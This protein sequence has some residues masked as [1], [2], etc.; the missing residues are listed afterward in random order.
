ME[1]APRPEAGENQVSYEDLPIEIDGV[2]TQNWA[3]RD[4][5]EE[6]I[7][8]K[9]ASITA[10]QKLIDLGLTEAEVQA[11]VRGMVR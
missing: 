4:L 3:V 7:E 6:E 9:N 8:S 11:L 10:R 5:T 1:E 2:I